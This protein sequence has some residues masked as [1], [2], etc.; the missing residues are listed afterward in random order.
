M[1]SID[2]IHSSDDIR[3]MS[4]PEL[5]TLCRELRETILETVSKTG[6]HLASNLGAVELTV[7]IHNVFDPEKDRI[8]FDVGHQCY[9]HKLLTG[10]SGDF[11]TLRQEGGLSGFPKP[12]ESDSDAFVAG[13]ASSAVSTALGMARARTLLGEDYSVVAVLGDGSL[14][15]GLA[16]EGLNS[17]G[18][19]KEPIIVILNDNGVAISNTVGGLSKYLSRQRMKPIYYRIKKHYR[20]LMKILPGGRYIYAFTHSIKL[21]LKSAILQCSVFED[22]GLRYIGPVDGHDV[23]QLSYMLKIAREYNEPVLL[24]A[25][26]QKGKGYGPAEE[27]PNLYHGVSP[28]DLEKGVSREEKECFSNVFGE[29]LC[30]LAAE[31]RRI[32]AITAA[33]EDGTGLQKFHERFPERFFDEGIAEE[34]CVS[35]AGGMAKQGLRPVFAVYSTFLQRSFDMLM[36]DVAMLSLP[37]VLAVDRAGL[38]G[39]DGETHNGIF[40]LAMLRQVPGMKIYSPSSYA[41]LRCMLGEALKQEGPTAVRYPRGAEGAYCGCRPEP[42]CEL[43]K[44]GDVTL[45]SYGILINEVLAAAELL[46]AKGK[47]AQVIKLGRL[48]EVDTEKLRSLAGGNRIMVIEDSAPEGSVGEYIRSRLDGTVRML[49][50]GQRFIRQGT[51][52]QQWKLCGLDAETL[53]EKAAAL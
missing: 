6:G 45:V 21:K 29:E 30:R 38:V 53:A 48:D 8:V 50:T 7:A 27:T 41:E 9:V 19:S 42:L 51:V 40:D 33:M 24:H 52:R 37:V 44:G 34:H 1:S 23:K 32:C 11:H 20:K 31:D 14:T 5:D 36:Q 22:M 49:N 46:A 3:N 17:V 15:G 28:F 47:E 13:H 2:R 12:S 35:M 43:R 4:L 26:T 18:Q 16:Y 39:A 10:R 25:V